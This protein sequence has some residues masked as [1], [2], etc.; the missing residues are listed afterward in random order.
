M[1]PRDSAVVG[2][3]FQINETHGRRGWIGAFVYATE[4]KSW[5]I[6]GFV[7]HL[8][9]HDHQ[10]QAFIRLRWEEIDFIGHSLLSLQKDP[11]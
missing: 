11:E 9:S 8:E 5:G 7:P 1:Q 3:V 10:T 4:I 2:D 6:L